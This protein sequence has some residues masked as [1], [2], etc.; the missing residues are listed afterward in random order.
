MASLGIPIGLGVILGKLIS[1]SG[2]AHSIA[3]AILKRASE[4]MALYSLALAC[5]LIGDNDTITLPDESEQVDYEAELV[6][7]YR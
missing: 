5:C 4:K 3:V 7:Q 6:V 1:D 2:G